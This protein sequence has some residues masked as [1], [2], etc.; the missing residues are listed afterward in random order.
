MADYPM[1]LDHLAGYFHSITTSVG[2]RT[3]PP[4]DHPGLR[5]KRLRMDVVRAIVKPVSKSCVYVCGSEIEQRI[6]HVV[7]P[8][9]GP[10][11]D[12]RLDGSCFSV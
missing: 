5:T 1:T 10:P 9:S 8:S 3:S 2:L 4:G 12:F 6:H 11:E 7:S